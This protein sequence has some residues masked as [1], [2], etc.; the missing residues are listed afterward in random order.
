MVYELL[1][2]ATGRSAK[3]ADIIAAEFEGEKTR[4]DLSDPALP[5]GDYSFTR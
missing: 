5:A 3:V 2:S 1:F 4:L